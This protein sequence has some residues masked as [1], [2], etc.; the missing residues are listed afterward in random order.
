MTGVVTDTHSLIWYLEHSARLSKHAFREMQAAVAAGSPIHV[1]SICLVELS[2]LVEK[3]RL[4]EIAVDRV[5]GHL[6]QPGSGLAI[7]PLD[8]NIV[9]AMRK[10]PRGL[11]PDMPDRIIAA[12][13]L[14]LDLPL[15]TRD[16]RIHASGIQVVW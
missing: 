10:I 6:K 2:Y 4:P 8:E 11:V 12:T 3:G 16:G 15:V 9:Q 7:S 13:A 5:Y 14:H 1:P